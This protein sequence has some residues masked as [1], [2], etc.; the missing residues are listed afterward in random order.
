[1][2]DTR[3]NI[4]VLAEKLIRTKGYNG[5]SYKDISSVLKI[6]NAAIH[7]HFPSKTDLGT[8]V[9]QRNREEFR[10]LVDQMNTKMDVNEKLN[11]FIAIYT[12]SH[13]NGLVCFMGALGPSFDHLSTEMQHELKLAGLEIRKGLKDILDE[14]KKSAQFTFQGSSQAQADT[15]IASLLASLILNK[16]TG[17]NILKNTIEQI[18]KNI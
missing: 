2:A 12:K 10:Q 8:A 15:I 16:V 11:K 17:E 7:Y 3:S 13:K 9:I 18:K 5:F 14:G 4:I 6:K 1:M